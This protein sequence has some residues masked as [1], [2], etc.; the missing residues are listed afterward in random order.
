MLEERDI[1][2]EAYNKLAK[3]YDRFYAVKHY[4]DACDF[5]QVVFDKYSKNHPETILDAGCGTGS[6]SI[7]LSLRNYEVTGID[8][9]SG[10][11][12][13]A[14]KK[15][16]YRFK[17]R[18]ENLCH[19]KLNERFDACIAMSNVFGYIPDDMLSALK[20]IRKH[21]RKHSLL[22]FDCWNGL[23]VL[24]ERPTPRISYI[25]ENIIKITYSE[26]DVINHMCR[27]HY[28]ILDTTDNH[29]EETQLYHDIRFYFPREMEHYLEDAKFKL[30]KISPLGDWRDK[31]EIDGIV[32][33]NVWNICYIAKAI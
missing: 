18:C 4:G 5:I 15:G 6:Y 8:S 26:L 10:M 33:E 22:I 20:N 12:E 24:N 2:S 17:F 1:N 19:L 28:H 23:A 14:L 13:E 31:F 30:L 16:D 9:S 25:D 27:V 29:L 11:I 3:Y 21:L 32:D 7:P